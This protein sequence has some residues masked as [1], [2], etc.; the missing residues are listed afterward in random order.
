METPHPSRG[1]SLTLSWGAFGARRHQSLML[2]LPVRVALGV[3]LCAACYKFGR[4]QE[5]LE[6]QASIAK[7]ASAVVVVE[8]AEKAVRTGATGNAPGTAV[9]EPEDVITPLNVRDPSALVMGPSEGRA[10]PPPAAAPPAPGDV[11]EVV[12]PVLKFKHVKDI[13]PN[14]RF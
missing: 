12:P 8:R 10:A 1:L 4:W 9:G 6:G 5:R 7:P 2:G 3:A 14:S 11:P 13:K